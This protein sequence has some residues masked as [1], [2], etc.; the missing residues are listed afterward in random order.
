[1]NYLVSGGTPLSLISHLLLLL[2]LRCPP[3]SFSLSSLQIL[4]P[5]IN[6]F[7]GV[8]PPRPSVSFTPALERG[9]S[10]PVE[11]GVRGIGGRELAERRRWEDGGGGRGG[12]ADSFTP[13]LP[14]L[15][16]PPVPVYPA[17]PSPPPTPYSTSQLG[18]VNI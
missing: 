17:L 2:L 18:L 15:T 8:S 14:H 10:A 16:Q 9:S 12:S 4:T 1:M 6:L 5:L 13:P 11:G 7:L 3:P